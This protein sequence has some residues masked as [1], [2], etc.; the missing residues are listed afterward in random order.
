MADNESHAQFTI[1]L[2]DG[3][4]L[5]GLH[6]IIPDNPT[7]SS[8]SKVLLVGVHGGTYSSSYFSAHPTDSL[9]RVASSL[10]LPVIAIDRPGYGGSTPLKD[11]NEDDDSAGSGNTYIQRQGDYLAKTI[12]PSLCDQFREGIGF[13]HI[14]VYGHGVGAL[15]SLVCASVYSQLCTKPEY[16]LI[17]LA[18][19]GAGDVLSLPGATGPSPAN[20]ADVPTGFPFDVK[21]RLMFNHPEQKL[22]PAKVLQLTSQLDHPADPAEIYDC[23]WQWPKY[24]RGYTGKI[25]IPVYYLLGA[26]DSMWDFDQC[27][28]RGLPECFSKLEEGVSFWSE[29]V[30]KAPHCV[31]LSFAALS[32][33]LR[34]LG[35]AMKA[36]TV[37]ETL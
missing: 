4:T 18:V 16:S 13:D 33:N 34:I 17:G 7:P 31:D 1:R 2:S 15:I 3:N 5:T 22:V 35:W 21:D 29:F 19:V 37:A 25:K 20:I 24:W 26:T 9:L 36:K 30:P 8:R 12:L 10:S 32:T 6:T 28:L 23:T 11:K 27:F 14:V